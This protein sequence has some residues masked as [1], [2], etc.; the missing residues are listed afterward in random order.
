MAGYAENS[1]FNNITISS[2]SI[3]VVKSTSNGYVKNAINVY[4]GAVAGYVIGGQFS[5][6]TIVLGETQEVKFN[7]EGNS[8]T[9][10]TFGAIAGYAE[11]CKIANTNATTAESNA[12][13]IS[14]ATSGGVDNPEIYI[15]SLVGVSSGAN[16]ITSNS[17]KYIIKGNNEAQTNEVG[18]QK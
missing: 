8:Q 4:V 2:T 14:T 11:S 13:T 16:E 17:C 9:K 6:C 12:F 10:F 3:N 1:T 5:R 7:I 15:G 18:K